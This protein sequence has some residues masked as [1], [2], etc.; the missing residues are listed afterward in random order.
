MRAKV[1]G[2]GGGGNREDM[3]GE[4]GEGVHGE[5]EGGCEWGIE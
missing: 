2:G 1:G 4:R 5:G 3:E